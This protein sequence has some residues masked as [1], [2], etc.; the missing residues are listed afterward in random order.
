MEELISK[1]IKALKEIDI[2]EIKKIK[3]EQQFEDYI[4]DKLDRILD[5]KVKLSRQC[6]SFKEGREIRPDISVGKDEILIELKYNLKKIND[7]YRL[8]YQAVKYS[9]ITK[10]ILILCAHDPNNKLLKSDIEDLESID[11][12]KVIHIY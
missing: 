7:I 11:K 1:V 10:Q 3:D 5:K 12:V 2:Y 4:Y 9:K 8:Y 6:K